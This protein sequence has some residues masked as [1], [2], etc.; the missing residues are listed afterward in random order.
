MDLRQEI[1]KGIFQLVFVSP[2]IATSDEF[3]KAVISKATFSRNLRVVNI[4]EAHCITIWGGTFRPD[5]ANLGILR[6]KF[7]SNVPFL[8][9]SATF[10]KHVIGD[11]RSKLRLSKDAIEV[12]LTNERPNVAL[13]VRV[14]K[15][16]ENSQR[17]LRFLIPP[18]AEK[19]EDMKITLVYCNQRNT[20]EDAA[21]NG[22]DWVIEQ[23]ISPDCIAFYHSN[24]GDKRKR[25]IE[26]L[27]KQ[28]V[29]RILFCTDAVGMVSHFEASDLLIA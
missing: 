4:D 13:S 3:H 21:D 9:A 5:Y 17:D 11:V 28:G 1:A 14:M 23:G 25:E 16:E 8:I 26:E 6:G 19:P 7:P 12:R 18:K 20:A 10:P 24:I 2:E 29:I 27:L 15:H 22:K